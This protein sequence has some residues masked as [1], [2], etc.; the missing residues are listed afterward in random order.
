ME[1]YGISSFVYWLGNLLV[2]LV[3][4]TL[5]AAPLTILWTFTEQFSGTAPDVQL[6]LIA[7]FYASSLAL[8]LLI[9][10]FA[11]RPG[12]AALSVVVLTL[13]STL[14]P[15]V[16]L[17]GY[18]AE[19]INMTRKLQLISCLIPDVAL[20][21][22]L[23][24]MHINKELGDRLITLDNMNMFVLRDVSIYKM[25]H[26]MAATLGVC[27]LLTMYVDKVWPGGEGV[28]E[29][30]LFFADNI[31]TLFRSV[32]V[33]KM[34]SVK[35]Y[36][37]HVTVLLGVNGSGKSLILKVMNG[38]SRP[39]GGT[40]YVGS[41]YDVR[42]NMWHVRQLLGY[43]PQTE[44]LLDELSIEENLYFF[45]RLRNMSRHKAAS[46]AQIMLYEFQLFNRRKEVVHRLDYN[47]RRRLQ[48][49]IAMIGWPTA[50]HTLAE[51]VLAAES[52]L[53]M[54][55]SSMNLRLD[56]Q[57]HGIGAQSSGYKF[58]I[59][60][61][62][63]HDVAELTAFIQRLRPSADLYMEHKRSVVYTIGYPGPTSLIELLR[64]LETN[65]KQLGITRIGATLGQELRLRVHAEQSEFLVSDAAPSELSRF[66]MEGRAEA[67]A[68]TL[69]LCQLDALAR[70]KFASGRRVIGLQ[71]SVLVLQL[72][73]LGF[74]VAYL[75][76]EYPFVQMHRLRTGREV[77]LSLDFD[78]LSQ[79]LHAVVLKVRLVI[80]A[81]FP[82]AMS[83]SPSL[84]L[85]CR[86]RSAYRR[87]NSCS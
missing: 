6:V 82:V 36:A 4:L 85:S 51:S 35:M 41:G 76:S 74:M 39:N 43:C 25:V 1:A 84:R 56:M 77:F 50:G 37:E 67:S 59:L 42:Q 22:A 2:E 13:T 11:T 86:C 40:V 32:T 78:R 66:D 33:L 30:P 71:A 63:E 72:G 60:M 10:S 58:T 62:E 34:V 52:S 68:S 75:S 46:E 27:L 53:H 48:L 5:I 18:S 15:V 26:A 29:M 80:G 65:Q 16:A 79:E 70:K 21:Y 7:F 83:L 61:E 54:V 55:G 45:A 17:V 19:Y 20:T 81:L 44:A 49:A 57:I 23:T 38:L 47:D 73:I 87:P 9:A 8:C 24:M 12:V 3:K 69:F 28:P 64:E 14:L 31:V